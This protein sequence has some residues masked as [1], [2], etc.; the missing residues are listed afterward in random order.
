MV[1]GTCKDI[2]KG[3]NL[4]IVGGISEVK[5]EEG[6]VWRPC[7]SVCDPVTATEQVLR[8]S[9][10]MVQ[11]FFTKLF[12]TSVGFMKIGSVTLIFFK[13]VHEFVPALYIFLGSYV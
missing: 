4:P 1:S 6:P 10:S 12:L 2:L 5:K 8:F 3:T 11:V 9:Y 13:A 7:L